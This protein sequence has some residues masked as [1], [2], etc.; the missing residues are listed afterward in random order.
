MYL[1]VLG[2]MVMGLVS[3]LSLANHFD[4]ES[5][6]VHALFSQDGCQR[7]GFWEVVRH[8]VSPF[9][10]SGTLLVGAGLLVLCSLPVPPVVKQLIQVVTMMPGQGG[11]FQS[12]CFP[13]R[14]IFY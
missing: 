11:Q 6:V 7:E 8:V 10:L 9:D 5:L 4:S 13:C 12:V 14:T 2:F 3:R 1:E